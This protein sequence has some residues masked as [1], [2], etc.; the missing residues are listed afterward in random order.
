MQVD[1]IQPLRLQR[2]QKPGGQ[3][4]HKAQTDHQLRRVVEHQTGEL[5]VV[6][7][8]GGGHALVGLR[9]GPFVL[10][11]VVVGGGDGCAAGALE[12]K[13]VFAV[14][15]DAD[16]GC[17]EGVGVDGVDDLLKYTVNE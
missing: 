6:L 8:A 2:R 16:D 7:L 9:M 10:E 12:A 5:S 17:R 13:G 14:G 1:D 11:Q 3:D 4:V 15:E